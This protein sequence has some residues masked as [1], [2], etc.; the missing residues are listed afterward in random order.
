MGVDAHGRGHVGMPADVLQGL[1]ID[2]RFR[3]G[4]N[5][6]VPEDVGRRTEGV[7]LLEDVPFDPAVHH[8]GRW[9]FPADNIAR[10]LKGLQEFD[11]L[12]IQRNGALAALGLGLRHDRLI[13]RVG[14]RPGNRDELLFE[15][16]VL[17]AQPQ[18]FAPAHTGEDHQGHRAALRVVGQ[19]LRDLRDDFLQLVRGQRIARLLFLG[20]N[21]QTPALCRIELNVVVFESGIHDLAEQ[22][23]HGVYGVLGEVCAVVQKLLNAIRSDF[24]EAHVSERGKQVLRHVAGIPLK[25]SGLQSGPLVGVEPL[26]GIGLELGDFL[27]AGHGRPISMEE[28]IDE[29]L[30]NVDT[31]D[32]II[33]LVDGVSDSPLVDGRLAF[34][35][36]DLHALLESLGHNRCSFRIGFGIVV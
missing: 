28:F 22:H 19:L 36:A 27:L 18:H 12:V 30:L 15:V 14:D 2:A 7:H 29:T 9:R 26:E 24:V 8:L 32:G 6:A 1:Q 17:P 13:G 16:D 3:H 5:V 11:Q 34:V 31:H 33:H 21:T 10:I 35:N 20:G 23:E 25:R 4:G